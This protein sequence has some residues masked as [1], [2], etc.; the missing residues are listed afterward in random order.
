[1]TWNLKLMTFP[2]IGF[3]RHCWLVVAAVN[4]SQLTNRF[5][6]GPPNSASFSGTLNK[7]LKSTR[8]KG[9]AREGW[10]G[11]ATVGCCVVML[12]WGSDYYKLSFFFERFLPENNN[13]FE[14]AFIC[15]WERRESAIQ[16]KRG[17]AVHKN[18]MGH[19]LDSAVFHLSLP[20]SESSFRSVS[21]G[22]WLKGAFREWKIS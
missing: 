8:G 22:R 1:M 16:E 10:W 19:I 17:S 9:D 11:T 21:L 15:V 20:P 7:Q 14:A 6:G 2:R 18:G 12:R 3:C 5:S 4:S 13:S